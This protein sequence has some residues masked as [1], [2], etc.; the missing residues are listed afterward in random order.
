MQVQRFN[1]DGSLASTSPAF[2]YSGASGLDQARDGAGAVAVQANGQAVVGGGHFLSTS[3]F[4]LGRVNADGTLDPAFGSG[5]TLTTTFNGDESV[6]AVVTQPDGKIIAVGFSENNS[7][8]HIFIALA[9]Y[10][11]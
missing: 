3:V 1:P 4:G 7:T 5:G 2:D 8:G 9:R 6:G 10:N 11:P